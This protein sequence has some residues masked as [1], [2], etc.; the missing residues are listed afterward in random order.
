MALT[1]APIKGESHMGNKKRTAALCASAVV[2]TLA[3]STAAF[4]QSMAMEKGGAVRTAHQRTLTVLA[5]NEKLQVIDVV[6]QPGDMGAA[7]SKDGLVVYHLSDGTIERTFA[8]GSKKVVTYKAGQ[9]MI[10]AEKRPYS[11]KNIGKTAIHE[12]VVQ[13]K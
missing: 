11:T 4:A 10:I 13:L 7:S 8:D 3:F 6:Y 2:L 9:T 1:L 5:E 12:I